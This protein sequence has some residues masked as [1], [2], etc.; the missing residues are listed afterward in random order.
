MGDGST[1]DTSPTAQMAPLVELITSL[2]QDLTATQAQVLTLSNALRS[3][4]PAPAP[5]KT[6]PPPPLPPAPNGPKPS[7]VDI[8]ASGTAPHSNQ[9]QTNT[10]KA[11][12]VRPEPLFTPDH[13]K[14]NRELIIELSSPIPSGV[15]H[16]TIITVVIKA[17]AS[18]KVGFCLARRTTRGNLIILTRPNISASSAEAYSSIIAA[19]L[20]TL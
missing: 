10:K 19:S 17:L 7:F 15:T 20:Q 14:V 12:K 18:T 16:Y 3:R 8:T 5:T 9:W 13:T 6:T 11:K 4:G 1:P 2:R